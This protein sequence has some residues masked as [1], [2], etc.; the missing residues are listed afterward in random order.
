MTIFPISVSVSVGVV[1]VRD[2]D[3]AILRN[4]ALPDRPVHPSTGVYRNDGITAAFEKESPTWVK[5]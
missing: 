4:W 1:T 3:T 2:M 5:T